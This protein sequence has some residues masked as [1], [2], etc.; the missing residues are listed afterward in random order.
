MLKFFTG[1]LGAL[2]GF[3]LG[4][5]FVAV[6]TQNHEKARVMSISLATAAMVSA[7]FIMLV[8]QVKHKK[9]KQILTAVICLLACIAFWVT[10][11]NINA[12]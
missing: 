2:V 9:I 8:N 3:W 7:L 4:L 10:L 6:F 11:K 1:L 5:V 12:I